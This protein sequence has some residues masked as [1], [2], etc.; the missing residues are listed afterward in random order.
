[1]RP[2]PCETLLTDPPA[3]SIHS[4]RNQRVEIGAGAEC[5]ASAGQDRDVSC[6]VVAKCSNE[7]HRSESTSSSIA[8]RTSGRFIVM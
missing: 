6:L 2:R 4:P 3:Q 7:R 8:F 5:V 1:M